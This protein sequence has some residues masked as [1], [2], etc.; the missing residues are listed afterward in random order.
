MQGYCGI[1]HLLLSLHSSFVQKRL[2]QLRGSGSSQSSKVTI[3]IVN[4]HKLYFVSPPWTKSFSIGTC[5]SYIKGIST[6]SSHCTHCH[7]IL[8]S[9]FIQC[10]VFP[11]VKASQNCLFYIAISTTLR[12]QHGV[13]LMHISSNSITVDMAFPNRIRLHVS[14]SL[15]SSSIIVILIGFILSFSLSLL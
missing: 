6:T 3:C 11:L 5:S 8:S 14:S 2:M 10:K 1:V 9:S 12:N 7:F 4:K 13:I 15:L